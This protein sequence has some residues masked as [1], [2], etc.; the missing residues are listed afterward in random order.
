MW[1]PSACLLPRKAKKRGSHSGKWRQL[2]AQK[3]NS[4]LKLTPNCCRATG[5][6]MVALGQ[7]WDVWASPEASSLVQDSLVLE[8]S[9][10]DP[11][12]GEGNLSPS[13]PCPSVLKEARG[14][15]FLILFFR[16]IFFPSTSTEVTESKLSNEVPTKGDWIMC[17]PPPPPHILIQAHKSL[18][19]APEHLRS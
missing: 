3:R 12:A 19:K 14:S 1:L 7:N 13:C 10:C 2:C 18:H 15:C 11:D 16:F 9:G 8:T 4:C 17:E 5:D 6:K